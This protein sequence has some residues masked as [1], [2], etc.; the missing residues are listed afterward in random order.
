MFTSTADAPVLLEIHHEHERLETLIAE[1]KWALLKPSI[2][3]LSLI[4]E[5]MDE[6]AALLADHFAHEEQGGYFDE[7][8]DLNPTVSAHVERLQA[9]HRQMLASVQKINRQLRHA[10]NTPLWFAMIR[11]AF[12]DFVQTCEAHQHEENSMMQEGYLRDDG[13]GD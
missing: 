2:A 1:L 3:H 9:Q 11:T 7:L 13:E 4:R 10:D 8:V 6:L 5:L 12:N